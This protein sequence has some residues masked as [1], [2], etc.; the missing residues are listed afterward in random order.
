MWYPNKCI[1]FVDAKGYSYIFFCGI[2]GERAIH[3][4]P[5]FSTVYT[6]IWTSPHMDYYIMRAYGGMPNYLSTI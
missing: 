6:R 1:Y 3:H 4:H 5:P 2:L